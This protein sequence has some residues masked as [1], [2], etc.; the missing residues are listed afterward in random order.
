MNFFIETIL[1]GNSKIPVESELRVPSFPAAHP[2]IRP[3][4]VYPPHFRQ[5][6]EQP[7]LRTSYFSP[8]E[9]AQSAILYS[10]ANQL[11]GAPP[12][13]PVHYNQHDT[14]LNSILRM[15]SKIE[16]MTTVDGAPIT[17]LSSNLP[18]GFP[19][20]QYQEIQNVGTTSNADHGMSNP[21]PP[22]VNGHDSPP[23]TP[24]PPNNTVLYQKAKAHVEQTSICRDPRLKLYT[25]SQQKLFFDPSCYQVP[26]FVRRDHPTARWLFENHIRKTAERK[27]PKR[28][29]F[30]EKWN[31]LT[32]E[33][34][35]EWKDLAHEASAERNYQIRSRFI[36]QKGLENKTRR[37]NGRP[38]INGFRV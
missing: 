18:L 17:G 6:V 27:K 34:K 33:E 23:G 2:I 26:Q 38:S 36:I 32:E 11:C 28:S 15:Q 20:F 35:Q 14:T 24:T 29:D 9:L 5:G 16:K 8:A 1:N 30:E 12:P 19:T 25:D 21:V 13:L 22:V 31:E 37:K 4:P 3:I 10:V 7:P